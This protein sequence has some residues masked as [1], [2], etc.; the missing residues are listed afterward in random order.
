MQ[1][2]STEVYQCEHCDQHFLRKASYEKHV[3]SCKK[4]PASE[5]KCF[6]CSYLQTDHVPVCD[7]SKIKNVKA[8]FCDRI[9]YGVHAQRTV[10]KNEHSIPMP[11]NCPLFQ[12]K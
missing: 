2:K 5:E 11:E 9:G 7:G 1:V 3:R 6:R 4:R 12:G 10:L 8:Y